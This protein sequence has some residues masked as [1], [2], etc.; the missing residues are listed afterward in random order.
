MQYHTAPNCNAVALNECVIGVVILRQLIRA[1]LFMGAL[2]AFQ[3][4]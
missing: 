3:W 1:K 4:V 2:N